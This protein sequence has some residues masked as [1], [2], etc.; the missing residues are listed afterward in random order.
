MTTDLIAF[1]RARLDEDAA[2]A[3]AAAEH[4]DGAGHDVQGAPGT[5]TFVPDEDFFGAV[6]P[7]GAIGPRV[8]HV[9]RAAWGQHIALHDPARVLADIEAK[10][11]IIRAH[12]KWCDGRCAAPYPEGG[13][14]AAHYWSIESLAAAYAAH[15]D[16][17]EEWRP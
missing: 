6:H 17:R 1:L 12:E 8:G 15:P 3:R 2:V 4:D 13:F 9:N 7:G 5:W 14:D 11:R 10:R 16:Y